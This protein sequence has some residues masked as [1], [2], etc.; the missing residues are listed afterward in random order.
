MKKNTICVVIPV[1]IGTKVDS[2]LSAF[3][4]IIHQ[5]YSAD[6]IIIVFDGNI[7]PI[8]EKTI[9]ELAKIYSNLVIISYDIN[10]GP[11]YARDIAIKKTNCH[12]IAIM[13]SDDESTLYRLY[14]QF[15]FMEKNKN[16]ALCGGLIKEYNPTNTS[17]I[18]KVPL[19]NYD[20]KKNIML[21]SPINNVT[22]FFRKVDYIEAG[23]YPHIRSSEDYALWCR[24]V[25]HNKEMANLNSVLVNVSFDTDTLSRRKGIQHFK[26]DLFT[27]N[28]MLA[29]NLITKKRYFINV[30]KYFI[31]R[32][33]LN[34]SMKKIAYKFFLRN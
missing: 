16:I 33:I 13:D 25:A 28:E 9:Y 4:S 17:S 15:E 7:S 31:F 29:S 3:N 22:A 26:N 8:L 23:G 10:R 18:R 19:S 2:F 24:F 5:S 30:F 14:E 6:E 32:C 1:Y 21:K 20:I 27:Q 11:G 12:Y 34:N